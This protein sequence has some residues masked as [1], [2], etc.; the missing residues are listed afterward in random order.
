MCFYWQF[1]VCL[2]DIREIQSRAG[3][4]NTL[5][6]LNLTLSKLKVKRKENKE[7]N[8]N[9]GIRNNKINFLLQKL[10]S[11]H[12][13][14]FL[15]SKKYEKIYVE[16]SKMNQDLQYEKLN[17]WLRKNMHYQNFI[18]NRKPFEYSVDIQHS[19]PKSFNDFLT[20][21]LSIGKF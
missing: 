15:Y 14:F 8:Q 1:A 2:E 9:I 3:T 18:Q 13:Q 21:N 16:I 7:L 19:I 20:I 12:K 4:V 11:L 10:E 17:S 5:T 6:W